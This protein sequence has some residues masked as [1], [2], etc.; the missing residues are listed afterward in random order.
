M[1]Q[2]KYLLAARDASNRTQHVAEGDVTLSDAVNFAEAQVLLREVRLK[3]AEALLEEIARRPTLSD[4]ALRWHALLLLATS[5]FNRGV[6]PDADTAALA[7]A[8]AYR[9]SLGESHP[10]LGRTFHTLGTIH[11]KLHDRSGAA[12][13]FARAEA[14]ERRSFGPNSVQFQATEIEQAWLDVQS[15]DLAAAERRAQ[16]ALMFRRRLCPIS[17]LRGAPNP[18]GLIAEAKTGWP[19]RWR[20]SRRPAPGLWRAAMISPDRFR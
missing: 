1:L 12:S 18:L 16:T 6:Y 20:I 10:V 13:F 14:I 19:K 3:D 9:T 7:A 17:D 15:G 11:N 8:E 4:P 5:R 2:A